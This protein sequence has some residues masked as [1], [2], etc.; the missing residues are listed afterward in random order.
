[1]HTKR[2][3]RFLDGL[4]LPDSDR[5]ALLR[6]MAYARAVVR[7]ALARAAETRAREVSRSVVMG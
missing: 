6:Q 3:R 4:R 7:A 2:E 5:R 1:M